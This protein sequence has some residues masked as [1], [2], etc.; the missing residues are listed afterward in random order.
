MTPDE[1]SAALDAMAAAAGDDSD[2]QPGLIE[3]LDA[4]WCSTMYALDHSS[5]T[6]ADGTRHRNIKILISSAFQT[7]LL[8]RAEAGERGEPYRELTTQA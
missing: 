7:R 8:T 5:K 2:K 3:I 6:L 4:D 1:L